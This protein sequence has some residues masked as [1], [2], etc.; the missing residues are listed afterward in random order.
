[1]FRSSY[2]KKKRKEKGFD[3]NNYIYVINERL[4]ILKMNLYDVNCIFIAVFVKSIEIFER[5]Q[6]S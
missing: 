6:I 3:P 2:T 5:F 1:M 4:C